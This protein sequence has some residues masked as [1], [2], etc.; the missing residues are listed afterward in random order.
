MMGSKPNQA[1]TSALA[2]R[3]GFS[4]IELMIA[5]VIFAVGALGYAGTSSFLSRQTTAGNVSTERK[6]ALVA[7]IERLRASPFDSISSGSDSIGRFG[8]QWSVVNSN[9]RSVLV[10]IITVG[11]G[12]ETPP[13]GGFP[14]LGSSVPD[15]FSY[16]IVDN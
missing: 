8:V 5:V 15:T 1:N 6:T 10:R 2:G 16:R 3:G 7:T 12:L 4:L 13:N 11:P 9:S 14:R